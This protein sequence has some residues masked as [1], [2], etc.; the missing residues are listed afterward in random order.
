MSKKLTKT[1]ISLLIVALCAMLFCGLFTMNAFMSKKSPAVHAESSATLRGAFANSES[2]SNW[3]Y[4]LNY[5]ITNLLVTTDDAKKPN[6]SDC[7]QKFDASFDKDESL[8][9]YVING[10]A[11][12]TYDCIIYGDVDVIYAPENCLG[13][14]SGSIT[15]EGVQMNT[16]ETISF[17]NFNTS[18]ATNMQDMFRNLHYLKTLDVSDFDTS[19]V[20]NMSYMFSGD[21]NLEKLDV[22]GFDTSNLTDA[23]AMFFSCLKL[24]ELNISSKQLESGKM[25]WDTSEVTDMAQMFILCSKLTTLDVNHFNTSNVTDMTLMFAGCENLTT[26]NVGNFNTNQTSDFI[27]MFMG[28]TGENGNASQQFVSLMLNLLGY[29]V[30]EYT[31]VDFYSKTVKAIL[32]ADYTNEDAKS[33]LETFFGT[34]IDDGATVSMKLKVLN[35][36]NFQIQENSNVNFMFE[37][38]DNL[39]TLVAPATCNAEVNLPIAMVEQNTTTEYATLSSASNGKTLVLAGSSTPSTG[40]IDEQLLPAIAVGVASVLLIACLLT[41]KKRKIFKI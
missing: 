31:D 30:P 17:Y 41:S 13:L 1:N 7:L 32:S 4:S 10:Q 25:S 28:A 23:T 39:Q 15:N 29:S 6:D 34:I 14:F 40:F 11:S 35:I 24:T 21:Y 26:L 8:F 36:N 2:N 5:N 19:S 37:K 18:K 20:T 33:V 12:G 9:A 3:Y 22:S 27:G 16:L 38:C